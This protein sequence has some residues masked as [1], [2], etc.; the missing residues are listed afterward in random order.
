MFAVNEANGE[1]TLL[2]VEPIRG[3]TPR[4]FNVTPDGRWLLAAGQDSNTVTVFSIDAKSGR[5]TFTGQT[6]DLPKPVCICFNS[7]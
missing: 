2:G 7:K 4:N 1:L 6:V 5:L 3:K